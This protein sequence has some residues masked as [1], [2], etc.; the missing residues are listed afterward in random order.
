MLIKLKNSRG[1]SLIETAV[2]L[3]IFG[4]LST[5]VIKLYEKYVVNKRKAEFTQTMNS[6]TSALAYYIQDEG[7]LSPAVP[8]NPATAGVNESYDPT[9]YPCPASPLYGPGDSQYGVEQ[10]DTATGLCL[11][12]AANGVMVRGIA[13]QRVYIGS[14]PTTT[15]KISNAHMADPYGRRLTYAVSERVSSSMP[16][17][18]PS[19]FAPGGATGG[20]LNPT[21]SIRIQQY[22]T[23]GAIASTKTNVPFVIIAHGENGA[24]AYSLQ[25]GGQVPCTAATGGRDIQNCDNDNNNIFADATNYVSTNTASAIEYDDTVIFSL[26][27]IADKEDYWGL[28]TDTTDLAALNTGNVGI[29]TVDPAQKLD[30]IGRVRAHSYL[31]SSD[32]RLKKDIQPLD[33][34]TLKKIMMMKIVTY[35]Y[36]DKPENHKKMGVI[37]QD[38]QKIYPGLVY[39]GSDGYLSVDYVSLTAPIIKGLQELTIQKDHEISDLK[40]QL[41]DMNKRLELLEKSV[42]AKPVLSTSNKKCYNE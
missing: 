6:V 32:L 25:G 18:T 23:A 1:F 4:I 40:K 19:V 7:L 24:G 9:H 16:I 13:G 34:S 12:T 28:G 15:L 22:D 36:T 2:V 31:H 27:G 20:G 5:A 14:I 35:N 33:D 37:A 8:N 11:A 42:A 29:G 41:L 39:E 21:G 30:V 3:I 10:R 26:K 17:S 38:I